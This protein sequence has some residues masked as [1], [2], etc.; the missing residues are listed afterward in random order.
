MK[1]LFTFMLTI[2][3]SIAFSPTTVLAQTTDAPASDDAA[4][5]T[6]SVALISGESVRGPYEDLRTA[7]ETDVKADFMQFC[8]VIQR[9]CTVNVA[10][11]SSALE[12]ACTA[13]GGQIVSKQATLDC[14]GK[15][16]NVPIPGGID[17]VI[18]NIPGCV[19]ASCNAQDLPDEI[20]AVFNMA[21]EQVATEVETAV[22]E[23]A[24]ITCDGSE[25]TDA[26]SG[27]SSR[28]LGTLLGVITIV[29]TTLLLPSTI[30]F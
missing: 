30:L 23:S 4:C 20:L 22:A 6:E 29:A 3:V 2:V 27:A 10:D 15:L 13:E 18:L 11:Y 19:G 28:S 16:M 9:K 25:V 1:K 24:D 26:N 21:V 7:I 14:S 5:I 12:S 8:S 17:I